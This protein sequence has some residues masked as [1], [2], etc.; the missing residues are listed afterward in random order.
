IALLLT[1]GL[2][3][4]W[5]ALA[6][7]DSA[8]LA[9]GVVIVENHRKSIEHLEGGIVRELRVRDGDEERAGDTLSN[10]AGTAAARE[11]D[12]IGRELAATEALAMR[13]RAERDGRDE[14]HFETP[15]PDDARSADAR[16]NE[17]AVFA[18]RRAARAG[19]LELLAGRGDQL[20]GEIRGLQAMIASKR[21]L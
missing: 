11:E 21:E 3:G 20:R 10:L 1:F 9:P 12:R 19:E 2:F 5:A 6:P 7:L 17:L 15:S 4:T 14:L 18:A 8:A 16:R 13:L